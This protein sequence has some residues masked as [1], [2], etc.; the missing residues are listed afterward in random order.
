MPREPF[1]DPQT[2]KIIGAAMA[3]HTELG[4]G[5]LEAVY[6][7]ALPIEFERHRVPFE[8]GVMLPIGYQGRALALRYYVDFICFGDVVVEV[9]ALKEIGDRETAQVI[10]YLKASKIRRGLVLNFGSTSLQHKR[11]VLG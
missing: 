5:F 10:N 11:L 4:C 7:A 2:F 3:V 6:Q 1:P 9:K 8:S